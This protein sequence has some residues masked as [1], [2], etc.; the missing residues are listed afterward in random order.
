MQWDK[1]ETKFVI[2]NYETMTVPELARYLNRTECAVACKVFHIGLTRH[3]TIP[4]FGHKKWTEIESKFV[5]ENYKQMKIEDMAK[6]LNRSRQSVRKFIQ[7]KHV[8]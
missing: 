5:C 6:Q 4:S 3:D 2:R 8:S 1:E 7:R